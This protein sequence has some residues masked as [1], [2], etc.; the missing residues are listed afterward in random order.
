LLLSISLAIDALW[1]SI[2]LKS[3]LVVNLFGA[4]TIYLL[5]RRLLVDVRSFD[6][7]FRDS[8]RP[9]Y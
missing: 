8:C 2:Y 3:L 7:T 4:P 9:W 5:D 6:L 1:L